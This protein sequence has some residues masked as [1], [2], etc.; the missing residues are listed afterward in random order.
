MSRIAGAVICGIGAALTIPI[1]HAVVN[2]V[3]RAAASWF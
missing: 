1:A 3:S 2:A